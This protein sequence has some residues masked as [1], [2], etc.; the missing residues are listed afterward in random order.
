MLASLCSHNPA[1]HRNPMCTANGKMWP[2]GGEII[3][4]SSRG[5]HWSQWNFLGEKIS[6]EGCGIKVSIPFIL[7]THT[8]THTHFKENIHHTISRL[9]IIYI[10][11]FKNWREYK[12]P[13][14]IYIYVF[15]ESHRI[16]KKKLYYVNHHIIY[17]SPTDNCF[18]RDTV[19]L[20]SFLKTY[21]VSSLAW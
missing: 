10:Y 5:F 15:T 9:Q 12:Q 16:W 13:L 17:N 20:L 11:I 8:H 7:C 3:P 14:H 2:P 18:Y 6:C 21:Y 19:Y 1:F 4:P